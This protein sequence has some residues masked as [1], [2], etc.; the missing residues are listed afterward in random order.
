MRDY[1]RLFAHPSPDKTEEDFL[2][3]LNPDSF[4]ESVG[5]AE[6]FLKSAQIG[7]NYQF[8]RI[9]YFTLDSDSKKEGDLIFNKTVGLRDNWSKN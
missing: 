7:L 6:P 8:Q 3:H 4:K 1:D 5:Y 2:T 9:G